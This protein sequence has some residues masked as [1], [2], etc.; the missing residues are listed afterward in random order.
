MA[1]KKQEL[2]PDVGRQELGAIYAKALIAVAERA[3]GASTDTVV[4]ELESFVS[5]VL[6]ARPD[7]E[8]LLSS[9]QISPDVKSGI[10]Q[11]TLGGRMSESL[12]TFLQVV[13]SKGRLDSLREMAKAARHQLN[14]LRQRI[15]VHVET[16]TP[17]DGAGLDGLRN[18]LVAAMGHEIDLTTSVD[19]DLIGGLVVRVGDTVYDGSIS[20]RLARM[21]QHAIDETYTQVQRFT[22]RFAVDS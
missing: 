13:A 3:N 11:R 5:D 2:S 19:S 4:E 21:R 7:F 15:E 10:L 18:R 20:N 17:L 16:A 9:P 1:N 14:A 22:E 12:L 6:T 8:M